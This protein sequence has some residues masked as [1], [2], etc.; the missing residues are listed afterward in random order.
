MTRLANL[1]EIL[2]FLSI[3]GVVIGF[4]GR[5]HFFPDLFCHFRIQATGTLI[6]AGALLWPLKRKRWS[7]ASLLFGFTLFASL[8]PFIWPT[9][10][11]GKHTHRLMTMNVLTGNPRKE[12]VTEYIRD[13]D[14][15][16]IL[17][18]EIDQTWV[19]V[20]DENL[21]DDWPYSKTFPRNDNFGIGIYSKVP[22]LQ[23]DVLQFPVKIATPSI[24]AEFQLPSGKALRIVVT[25]AIPPMN[26]TKWQ[27][28]NELFDYL[29]RDVRSG[30]AARTLVAGDLN[31]T[32]WSWHF[33]RLLEQ[34][35]LKNSAK[36]HGVSTSWLPVPLA[37]FGLPIDHVLVGEHVAVVCR[38]VG[39]YLASDHRPVIMDFR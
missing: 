9:S 39:P 20:L 10:P 30:N 28:R 33:R 14:P 26:K 36:G 3:A 4:F 1:L 13:Q 7:I 22:W 6:I 24:A 37:A 19:D 31:C 35:E 29:A 32:P 25:H 27:S 5:W 16:F 8:V 12:L 2:S 23:C 38:T 21:L 18:Q 34:S 11:Q 15:D 17:L